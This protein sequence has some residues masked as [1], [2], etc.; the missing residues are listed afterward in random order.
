MTRS[1]RAATLNKKPQFSDQFLILSQFL[2]LDPP[3]LEKTLGLQEEGAC[4][5][6]AGE[7]DKD[8][9]SPVYLDNWSLGE[10]I[11]LNMLRAIRPRVCVDIG[12]E[13]IIMG[14]LLGWRH[15]GTRPAQWVYLVYGLIQIICPKPQIYHWNV[16]T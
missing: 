15:V 5:T 9:S 1:L 2:D 7:L 8:F 3:W 4:S 13:S 14:F 16:F 10:R 6:V 12:T 11:V